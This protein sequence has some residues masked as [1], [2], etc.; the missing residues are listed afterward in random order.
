MLIANPLLF[1]FDSGCFLCRPAILLSWRQ[2]RKEYY[3]SL[4]EKT[5]EKNTDRKLKPAEPTTLTK[6][7]WVI[8]MNMNLFSNPAKAKATR[9]KF[10]STWLENFYHEEISIT[11]L[12][13]NMVQNVLYLPDVNELKLCLPLFML[14]SLQLTCTTQLIH[15]DLTFFISHK[16][17]T[18][19]PLKNWSG[20]FP[21]KLLTGT[22]CPPKVKS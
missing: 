20:M 15:A 22:E 8:L 6:I 13:E 9:R 18:M 12:Q 19:W 1:T 14:L 2:S 11:K 21:T 10:K 16:Q 17:N 3:H 5:K 4:V 7:N